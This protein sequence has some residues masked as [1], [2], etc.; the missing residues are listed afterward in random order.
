MDKLD[1]TTAGHILDLSGGQEE[2]K[3]LGDIQLKGAVALYNM[4][5][6]PEVGMGYLADEVGMGKTYIALSV[7]ALMR[8]F[9]PTLRVLYICPSRNVQEKWDREYKSFTHHNVKV[10][11]NRIRTIEGEPASPYVSCRNVVEM[12]KVAGSGYYADFFVGK[13][14]FSIS[15]S[16]DPSDDKRE[17]MKKCEEISHLLPAHQWKDILGASPQSSDELKDL[18][19]YQYAKALNY[20]LPTFDLVVIDESHNFKH[21]FNSSAR[22]RVLSRVLGFND[23]G[24][25]VSRVKHSLLLSATPYDRD[26]KQLK[27]QLNL[28]GKGH[29]IN[30][31]ESPEG[32]K[33]SLQTFMVRRLNTLCING[34]DHTRNMYRVEHRTGEKAEIKLGTDEQKLVTALV[35]K[36]VGDLMNEKGMSSSFQTGMLSSF[37]SYAQTTRSDKVKFDGDDADKRNKDAKDRHVIDHIITSYKDAGLGLTLPHPKMDSVCQDLS[38]Q[39][40]NRSRKQIVFVRR[41]R[42]VKEIKDKLDDAYSEWLWVYINES[43]RG[44]PK[45]KVLL[46][47]LFDEYRKQS[48]DKDKDIS[49]GEFREGTAEGEQEDSQPPKNDTFF[50]WYFRGSSAPKFS[51]DILVGENAFSS[52]GD[53][54][55]SLSAKSQQTSLLFEINWAHSIC[56]KHEVNLEELINKYAQEIIS[57]SQEYHANLL[58]NDYQDTFRACQLGFIEWFSNHFNYPGYR[59]IIELYKPVTTKQSNKV[60]SDGDLKENLLLVTFFTE[61]QRVN[62]VDKLFPVHIKLLDEITRPSR[63]IAQSLVL[64]LLQKHNI[65]WHLICLCVRTGHGVVDL[66]ISRMKLGI[67]DLDRVRRSKL[68]TSF[69]ANLEKQESSSDFSTWREL[70]LTAQNLDLIIKNNLPDLAKASIESRRRKISQLLNPVAPIIGAT[71][72]TYSSRSA[73]ARKFRMPGYPLALITTDVFQE[74]EDLHTFC[75]SVLHYGITGSPTSIEQKTGRIDR[76]SSMAQRRLQSLGSKP[77]E[78]GDLIQVS[79]PHIKESIEF[80]QV[81]NLCE[82]LN[83][84]TKSLHKICAEQV[85]D[86]ENIDANNALSDRSVIPSQI[87]DFLESPFVPEAP[88]ELKTTVSLVREIQRSAER[89]GKALIHIERLIKKYFRQG[90]ISNDIEFEVTVNS[91]KRLG[92]M[93]LIGTSKSHNK[94]VLGRDNLRQRMN[95]LSWR[96]FHRVYAENI[97]KN[98]YHLFKNL[99]MLVGDESVTQVEDVQYF[100]NDFYNN[101]NPSYEVLT[102]EKIKAYCRRAQSEGVS[103]NNNALDVSVDYYNEYGNQAIVFEFGRSQLYRKHVVEL[104]EGDGYCIF[105]SKAIAADRLNSF[106]K[107]KDQKI[108]EY[109][110]ERN[111]NIDL[112]EFLLDSDAGISGRVI[113][114]M[115]HLDWEE[116]IFC[117]YLLAAESDRLEY[118]VSQKDVF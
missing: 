66:Y 45:L 20:V 36:K 76:V 47:E 16:N 2:L 53:L 87:K 34:K 4:I 62:Q 72:E 118:L 98:E 60:I 99:E 8:Y 32:I 15:L 91:T 82:N 35:Q 50:S 100:F 9:N 33:Q 3:Q 61:I 17:W 43:L 109:T 57:K 38:I 106:G 24:N 92:E 44:H 85:G 40:F 42:S 75:D 12:I 58:K 83:K 31:A 49:E 63:E 29:L 39:L 70:Y 19:K 94:F 108:I 28:V 11:Q 114:P 13:D 105:I 7:V 74:G 116:F 56:V 81:R 111:K 96:T 112:V 25:Y 37:E 104:Y 69:V 86:Q 93:L 107:D 67:S 10:A 1:L 103:I 115:A 110:W 27:N 77:V 68:I 89:S 88:K 64:T 101:H 95:E 54:R 52:P 84:Y 102:S 51:K 48:K 41:V 59:Q 23:E 78:E 21:D 14:S 73:Q 117:S 26:I 79:F 71:G 46:G 55:K 65:H 113:H 80:L 22:N 18:V 5:A 97:G 6:D 90:A 30:V